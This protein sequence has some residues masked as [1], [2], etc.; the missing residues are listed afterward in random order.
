MI[1]NMYFDMQLP[2]SYSFCHL[3]ADFGGAVNQLTPAMQTGVARHPM[4]GGAQHQAQGAH[5]ALLHHLHLQ[6][7]WLL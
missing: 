2:E 3:V 7:P 1:L 6:I 4:Q 5:E